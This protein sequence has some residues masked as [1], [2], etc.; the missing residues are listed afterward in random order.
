LEVDKRSNQPIAS[1]S[2]PA[3][4]PAK[5]LEIRWRADD[6]HGLPAVASIIGVQRAAG[7]YALI[8]EL[9][10]A[11]E[12]SPEAA[13]WWSTDGRTWERAQEFPPG[14]R[15]LAMT[16]AGPGFIAGGFGADGTSIWTS[17]DGRA[18]LPVRDPSLKGAVVGQLVPTASGI[19]GFGWR[20]E[21]DAFAI[22]TSPDGSDW[23]DATNESGL[24]VA[25]GLDAVGS[26]GG[27]AVA[28]VS[29]GE[30]K[31]DT[32]WETTGRAEWTRVGALRETAR[33]QRVVGG[34]RGWL[35]LG[36]NLAWTSADGR[37]WSRGVPGPDV[38]ADAI[39]DDAGF[40]AVGWV[41]S[42]P[43]ETCGDQ[44][45][46]AGHT[47]TSA[48][49]RTWRKMPITGEFKSA[50]ITRLL[51]VDRTLVG[52]GGRLAG[53]ADALPVGRWTARLP[54]LARPTARSD[55]ATT[56]VSCGG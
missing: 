11:D 48:D 10:Y 16:A 38:D 36:E 5:E 30:G 18:W 1:P 34:E 40:V 13:A 41:G 21:S 15:I 44:R 4:P 45:P 20:S 35:A 24:D 14:D 25:R 32:I 53:G 46:F 12:G 56:P 55:K 9:P 28:F 23:L 26:Y 19:V 49:G 8:G 31:P 52:Y 27:R 39:V 33:I 7:A 22:Y 42:V 47:W 51:V 3:T 37:A 29:Q 50:M 2:S 6:P 43:G 54:D 17:V